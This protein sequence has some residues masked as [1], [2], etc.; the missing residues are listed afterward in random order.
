MFLCYSDFG[1]HVFVLEIG[2]RPCYI[3]GMD[4]IL[5]LRINEIDRD[6]HLESDNLKI[7]KFILFPQAK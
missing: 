3:I 4:P 7:S 6:F 5:A 1:A 2:I